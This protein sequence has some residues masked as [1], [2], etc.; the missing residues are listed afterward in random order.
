MRDEGLRLKPYRC[1]AGKLTIG[2]GRNLEDVGITA[3]EARQM[4]EHDVVRCLHD[5]VTFFPWFNGLNAARQAVI[6]NLRYNLGLAGVRKFMRMFA[7][8]ARGDFE[9]AADELLASKWAGQVGDRATRLARQ[10][11]TGVE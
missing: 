7:A 5:C 10:L 3:Y 6:V 1:T 9:T 4:L 2:Y 11:H 8:I